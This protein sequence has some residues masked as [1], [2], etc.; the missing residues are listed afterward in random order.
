MK[1][2]IIELTG[3]ALNWAVALALGE[4]PEYNMW[5]HGM[6]WSGIFLTK[7]EYKKCPNYSTEWEHGGPIIERERID[8]VSYLNGTAGW[9]GRNLISGKE[10][11]LFGPTPLIAAM[12]C[13]VHSKLGNEVDIPEE[14]K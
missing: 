10:V 3:P 13:F 5:S 8:V 4:M 1:I 9:L 7:G 11:R 6:L 2:K 14:L 12:R